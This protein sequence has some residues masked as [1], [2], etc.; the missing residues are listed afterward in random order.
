MRTAPAGDFNAIDKSGDGQIS[1]AEWDEYFRSGS[2]AS[3]GATV[4]P[5]APGVVSPS[6]SGTT[7]TTAGPGSAGP[8]TAPS[9]DTATSPST[10]GK[11]TAK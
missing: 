7:G 8:Q 1:R 11:G 6:G 2:A 9:S 10:S 4:A 3:G 5:S